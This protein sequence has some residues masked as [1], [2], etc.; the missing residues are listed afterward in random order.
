MPDVILGGCRPEPLSAYLKALGVLRLVAEQRDSGVRGA[1]RKE[2]FCLRSSLDE[3]ALLGFFAE[4]Y[5]PTPIVGAW[6]S[7]CGFFAK[8]ETTSPEAVKA[9]AAIEQ[10]STARLADYRQT[11]R[12][13]RALLRREYGRE[14]PAPP[15]R[16]DKA[17][18][19]RLYRAQL[20]DGANLW[21][22][23][24]AV[25]G[26]EDS[27]FSPLLGTGGNDGRMSFSV[28]FMQRLVEL[29]FCRDRR[30]DS[31]AWLANALF[32]G[33]TAGLSDCSIGQFD[34]AHG[35]GVNSGQGRGDSTVVNP[36][37]YVLML[38]GSLLLAGAATRRYGL[39]PHSRAAF[40]FT[41]QV[42]AVSDSATTASEAA[43]AS[44]EE[45]WLPLWAAW[46]SL[47]ELT[48]VFAE[49]RASVG[50]TPVRVGVD[51]ARAVA[52]MG[53]DRGVSEFVRFGFLRRNGRAYL[54]V[55]S[56]R[57]RVHHD[58]TVDLLGEVDPW[59]GF[60][61]RALGEHT[62][63]R[64]A[65]ALRRFDKSVMDHAR[66]GGGTRLA[67]VLCALGAMERE[68][69]RVADKAG[70]IGERTLAPAPLLSAQWRRQ[71]DDGSLEFAV[72]AAL[73]SLGSAEPL[74]ERAGVLTCAL[75]EN[76]EPVT[77][78][79]RRSA[80][81][82]AGRR[83]VSGERLIPL[84]RATLARRLLDHGGEGLAAAAT[85][86]PAAVTAF[87]SGAVDD[88]R[89]LDLLWGLILVRPAHGGI[90][91][92]AQPASSVRPLPRSY[93]LLKLL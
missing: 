14:R 23:A 47:P 54:A 69:S 19:L 66:Y 2:A 40:P 29:G 50:N 82:A 73:A 16:D 92:R 61:R 93:A 75:R 57:F 56:G 88:D 8:D 58:P 6:A 67:N 5:C 51:F 76:L 33:V 55:P 27:A 81:S 39:S 1:W 79:G 46:A 85:L 49:G 60:Y 38:E 90:A 65:A 28:N 62:P 78:R 86:S 48:L 17:K 59:L 89:V 10:S 31:G 72:A 32:G 63:P 41:V 71:A 9:V 70:T 30:D 68:L 43:T 22:D 34:P 20:P 36:W 13:V 52:S 7:G 24:I 18:L 64:F 83:L 12:A 77:V 84:L 91:R 35:G 74:P 80:W 3:T 21:L 37:D 11:I 4:Q 15:D 87:L 53:V 42:T 44:R 25:L 45:I 26:D